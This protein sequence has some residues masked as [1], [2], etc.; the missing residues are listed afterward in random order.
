MLTAWFT[1]LPLFS[2]HSLLI[3]SYSIPLLKCHLSAGD[4]AVC[5]SRSG[6]T[7]LLLNYLLD[8]S[9]GSMFIVILDKIVQTELF[10]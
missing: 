5:I 8:I 7:K 2:L 4:S 9:T 3:E 1:I 10:F 6:S